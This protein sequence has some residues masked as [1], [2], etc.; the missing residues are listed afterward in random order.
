MASNGKP[1]ASAYIYTG[2]IT[3]QSD[4]CLERADVE[5]TDVGHCERSEV[6]IDGRMAHSS[7]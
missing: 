5:D 4:P 6:E 1:E 3:Y 2:A 7:T